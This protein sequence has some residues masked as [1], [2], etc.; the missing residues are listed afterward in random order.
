MFFTFSH[1]SPVSYRSLDW[2][3]NWCVPAVS[4]LYSSPNKAKLGEGHRGGESSRK[5]KIDL[6]V[7][8]YS[9]YMSVLNTLPWPQAQ[10]RAGIHVDCKEDGKNLTEILLVL[11]IYLFS[12]AKLNVVQNGV[13]FITE[14]FYWQIQYSRLTM[15]MWLMKVFTLTPR[16]WWR[17]C[18]TWLQEG[19]HYL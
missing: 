8:L 6:H 17:T 16:F 18:P 19:M 7:L 15:S 11:L 5:K 3:F 9:Y 2:S 14:S 1:S 13:S 4:F 12:K 10:I